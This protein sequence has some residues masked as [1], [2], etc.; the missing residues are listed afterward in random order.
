MNELTHYGVL[1]M[2]WGRRRSRE[3]VERAMKKTQSIRERYKEWQSKGGKGRKIVDGVISVAGSK[4]IFSVAGGIA[5][6]A[7]KKHTANYLNRMGDIAM[8]TSA[9]VAT[10][11]IMKDD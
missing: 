3:K 11:K 8:L 1:G 10:A 5:S 4:A 2:R 9:A 7:G 6:A